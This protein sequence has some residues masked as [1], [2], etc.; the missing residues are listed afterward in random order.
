MQAKDG[1]GALS[2]NC[3]DDLDLYRA[4]MPFIKGGGLFIATTRQ[5]RIGEGVFALVT[6]P[7]QSKPKPVAA[8]V[9]W[10]TPP[11]A[12]AALPGIGIQLGDENRELVKRIETLLVEQAASGK[13]T[14]TM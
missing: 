10:I 2:L 11:G 14:Y 6:L 1:G 13:P 5:Y 9:A 4:Y 3:K 7:G 8:R 12:A